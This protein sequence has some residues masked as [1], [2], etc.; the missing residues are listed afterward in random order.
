M[1]VLTEEDIKFRYITPAIERA[2]WQKEQIFM[3]YFFTDGH[4]IVRGKT[5]HRG[6]R[7]KADYLL[8]H[9]AAQIP[10]GIVEA[11]DASYA[12]G[13]GLQQAM[14]YARILDVPFAYSSNGQGFI[15]HDFYTGK[16]RELGLREFPS[17]DELWSRYLRGKGLKPAEENVIK[18][19]YYFDVFTQK[20]PRYYQRIAIDRTVEAIAKGQDRILLVMA[21]GTGKTFTAM[22]VIWRLLNSKQVRRVLYL[23]DRN[24]LIDQ[25]MQQDFKPFEKVMTKVQDKHL[26]SSYEIYMSL[27]H[28]LVGDDGK[29]AFRDF[30]P[31]FFDLIVVDECHRGSAKADSQ[32]RKVLDYFHTA[33]HIGM[34]ATPKET[35]EVSNISYF[36]E[37]IYTYSLKQGIDDGFLAPYKVIR[38]G[39][40]KDLEGWRP[41]KGQLDI[42]GNEIEDREYNVKDYDRNLVIDDRTQAVANRISKWLKANGRFSKTIIFCVD[43]DHAERMRLAM[44][45]ENSDLVAE[46][47]KYIMR[48]TG[49]N[50]EGKAQLD[51]FIDVNEQYPAV[52]TTSKLMTTGVDVKTCKLIVLDTNINSMT[53]F[54][55]IIGRGTRLYPDYGK[56][57]FTI[58]DFRDCCRLFADPE[59]DGEPVVIIDGGDGGEGWNPAEDDEVLV[60]PQEPGDVIF[61]PPIFDSPEFGEAAI[62]YRVRGVEVRILNERVQYY[63]TDGK[64]ITESI[65]DYS[66]RNI[67]DEYATLDEFL[68]AWSA[69]DK[70]QAV[71][72]ELKD[73]GVLLDALREESR[74]DLDEFDLILHIAF[75][76]K[77]LTKQER[78]NQVKKQ[79]YLYKYSEVCQEVLSALMDKYMN[80]GI[81]ELEDTR[82]LDNAPFDR[83]GSPRKI[84]KLFGGKAAYVAAVN[85]LKRKIYQVA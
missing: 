54:K 44:V 26:D 82:V 30:Q 77:P 66:K 51:Y 16:E 4:V 65:K 3:E 68:Q 63:D 8:V 22:Q 35:K 80:E 53:E 18:E 84:A 78:I 15:E 24:I 17:C 20:R 60:P 41:Y 42:Y 74:E 43:I 1:S 70:K 67:L 6:K 2:A 71:V 25:T 5:V 58:M 47:P 73:R 85:E 64:L 23:A 61:D 21:T 75:D 69:A 36:G 32:W 59:F 27:Y 38:I 56:E 79:G 19:P 10:L 37:P 12:I 72:D 13:A 48:I 11:K 28:Q 29:E 34:T 40:D 7:K 49:D 31:E 55:Q 9:T 45:N 33:I 39:L 76:K 52:V 57:Y 46:N 50:P 14:E 62:K 83:I 81:S